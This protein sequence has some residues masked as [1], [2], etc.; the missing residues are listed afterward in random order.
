MARY[1]VILGLVAIFGLYGVV[2]HL[3]AADYEA[4]QARKAEIIREA[5][6]RFHADKNIKKLTGK[7]NEMLYPLAQAK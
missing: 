5:K 1:Q 3:D 4:E 6:A 2:G 7:A